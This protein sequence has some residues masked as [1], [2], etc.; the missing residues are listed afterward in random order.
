MDK[1]FFERCLK[2]ADVFKSLNQNQSNFYDGYIRGMR[3]AFH[4]SFGTDA[5]HEK[6]M[7]ISGSEPDINRRLLG[8]GYKMGFAG[9]DITHLM[10]IQTCLRCGWEFIPTRVKRDGAGKILEI[11][12][13]KTCPNSACNSP[14]WDKPRTKGV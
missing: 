4:G 9:I 10:R 3:R 1:T 13:P 11:L 6:Y 7:A 12:K 14:Y 8:D 5:E 2:T